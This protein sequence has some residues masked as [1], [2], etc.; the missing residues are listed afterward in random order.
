MEFSSEYDE[1]P[2]EL[3]HRQDDLDETAMAL[4]RLT[5]AVAPLA[6]DALRAAL[7]RQTAREDL[8]RVPARSAKRRRWRCANCSR[9]RAK[10][11]S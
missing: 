3:V 2:S 10:R 5:E 9:T 8:G 4:Q 7:V 11:I 1:V 6:F